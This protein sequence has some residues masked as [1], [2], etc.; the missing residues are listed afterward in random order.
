[1]DVCVTER[2]RVPQ[3]PEEIHYT[4]LLK[5]VFQA[6][7]SYLPWVLE[8]ELRSSVRVVYLASADPDTHKSQC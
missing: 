7:L 3:R 4:D 1:M 6:G 5:L 2:E 8:T